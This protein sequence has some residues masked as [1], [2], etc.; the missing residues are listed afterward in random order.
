MNPIRS[1]LLLFISLGTVQLQSQT[2]EFSPALDEVIDEYHLEAS[3]PTENRFKSIRQLPTAYLPFIYGMHSEKA[4]L[5]IYVAFQPYDSRNPA[6]AKPQIETTR[7]MTNA[8]TNRED[9][10]ITVLDLSK[11]YVRKIFGADWGKEIYFQP[12]AS[13]SG[14]AHCRMVS[15]FKDEVG[16]LTLFFFFNEKNN[17]LEDFYSWIRFDSSQLSMPDEK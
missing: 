7:L 14:K 16:L 11:S 2:F 15:I 10:V 13:I 12:K 8:A 1:I 17:S 9:A 3:T 4:G 5:E 6:T